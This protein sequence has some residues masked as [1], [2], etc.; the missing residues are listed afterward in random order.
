VDYVVVGGRRIARLG[1]TPALASA[2]TGVRGLSFGLHALAAMLLLGA[3]TLAPSFQLR[4]QAR[5][6]AAAGLVSLMVSCTCGAPNAIAGTLIYHS[7][8]LGSVMLQTDERGEAISHSVY[9][10]F[11]A[12]RQ[13]TSEP[14]AFTGREWEVDTGLYDFYARAYDPALGRFLSPDPSSFEKPEVGIPDPQLLNP[15]S[16]ARN[17][18]VN[19]VDPD[20]R[21]AIPVVFPDYK[22]SAAGTKWG[23]LGHAGI[24]LIDNKTGQTRYYEYGRYDKA[25]IGETRQRKVPNVVIDKKTGMPTEKS[26]AA[27][28]RAVT[29][30]SGQNTR[31]EGAYVKDDKFK[32]MV[33]YAESRIKENKNS[34]REPYSLTGNNCG[35]F[36]KDVLEAGGHDTPWMVDPRPNSYIRELRS[37]SD[38]TV[39]YSPAKGKAKE[40]LKVDEK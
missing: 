26:L 39:D 2:V 7:D 28:L 8:H 21:D 37:D 17:S 9:E 34:D 10:P 11:G 33:T 24:I 12:R 38:V 6:L 1:S 5:T 19:Y 4:R 36:M 31:I 14:Y 16:Y 27:L 35:T 22:I 23:G 40:Q 29:K 15:Y 30:T 18:P 32:E 13:G 3:A 20:G 25:A